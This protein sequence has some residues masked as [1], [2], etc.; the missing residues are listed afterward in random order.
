MNRKSFAVQETFALTSHPRIRDKTGKTADDNNIEIWT[1]TLKFCA[2]FTQKRKTI[3][4]YIFFLIIKFHVTVY[5]QLGRKSIWCTLA[6][7]SSQLLGSASKFA[8]SHQLLA[9]MQS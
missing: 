7:V 2:C 1:N 4:V 5:R 3:H 6:A 9:I 8:A